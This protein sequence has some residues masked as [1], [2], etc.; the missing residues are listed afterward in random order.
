MEF[1]DEFLPEFRELPAFVKRELA[2]RLERLQAQGPLLGRPFVD[3][4]K[5]TQHANMKE[6]RFEADG[7]VWRVAFAFDPER[8]AILL[9]G[10]DKAGVSKSRFYTDLIEIADRRF[11]QHLI[12]VRIRQQK[13][14]DKK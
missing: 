8:T 9:V 11:A 7:G 1:H 10:G 3:T 14:N 13:R 6:L 4:L 5:G 2:A 12:Q